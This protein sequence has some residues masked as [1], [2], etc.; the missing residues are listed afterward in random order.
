MNTTYTDNESLELALDEAAPDENRWLAGR[1]AFYDQ[2]SATGD[3][4]QGFY[5]ALDAAA[6]D[7]ELWKAGELVLLSQG[8]LTNHDSPSNRFRDT[9]K[10]GRDGV[11]KG[12]ETVKSLL[13]KTKR[14]TNNRKE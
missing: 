2:V 11:R 12:G 14:S 13:T 1:K 3:T 7:Q 8:K 4:E 5:D 9:L 6:P 10:R